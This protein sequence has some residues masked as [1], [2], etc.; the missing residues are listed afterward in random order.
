MM[1]R[2]VGL[3]SCWAS[4][5]L[6]FALTA[7]CIG[8]EAGSTRPRNSPTRDAQI[9]LV[10]GLVPAEPR[11]RLRRLLPEPTRDPEVRY[12]HDPSARPV[13][14][15]E[16]GARQRVE[17]EIAENLEASDWPREPEEGRERV[18][19][20]DG[21]SGRELE[22]EYD[23]AELAALGVLAHA[24]G[25][26][27]PSDD[28][29]LPE[30][31]A[32]EE[33]TKSEQAWSNGIDSRINKNISSSYPTTDARLRK[34]GRLNGGC[35]GTLVGRRMV[36]TAA[37]CVTN[38]SYTYGTH[39]FAPRRDGA[40]L[41]WG[42]PSSVGYWYPS[43]WETGHCAPGDAWDYN[44]CVKHDWAL[45]LL[46]DNVWEVPPGTIGII[47]PGWVGYDSPIYSQH[48][49]TAYAYNDGYPN[50]GSSTIGKPNPCNANTAYGQPGN[51]KLGFPEFFSDT[52]YQHYRHGCDTS[53]GHSGSGVLSTFNNG[54]TL[55]PY[56]IGI[57]QWEACFGEDC[58]QNLTGD[59][60]AFPS[61]M[62][63]M[64]PYLKNFITD[65]KLLYP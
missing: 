1:A 12:P 17:A 39:S 53:A 49:A 22:L 20:V 55:A 37:H 54:V 5:L 65:K 7:V 3:A 40:T 35:S 30:E 14:D 33:P 48:S 45:V 60:L 24:R 63:A 18:I 50:C 32:T 59:A 16:R 31:P 27:N 28:S 47:P 11:Q 44:T 62:R 51:C 34:L 4:V 29:D 38:A 41:P 2:L 64:T 9:A 19:F 6:G 25:L 15:E 36:L 42:A 21:G 8:C 23:V 46:P 26:N 43:A 61:G 56:L 52:A 13:T 57:H 58:S 10:A